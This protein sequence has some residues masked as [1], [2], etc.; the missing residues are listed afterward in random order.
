L[1]PLS[2]SSPL[3]AFNHEQAFYPNAQSYEQ[4]VV[5]NAG[6]SINLQRN[7]QTG[8]AIIREWVDRKVG[9]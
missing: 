8:F 4:A 3:S 1:L 9:N 5:P 7:A 6:H 2:C